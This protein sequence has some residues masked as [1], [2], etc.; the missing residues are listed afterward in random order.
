MSAWPW[1]EEDQFE[2]TPG[3]IRRHFQVRAIGRPFKCNV[4]M[5][6]GPDREK[7]YEQDRTQVAKAG[8]L[9]TRFWK[10]F[11]V[12]LSQPLTWKERLFSLCGIDPAHTRA[13][14]QKIKAANILKQRAKEEAAVAA[15]EAAA[16]GEAPGQAQA[17]DQA[18]AKVEPTTTTQAAGAQAGTGQSSPSP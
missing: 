5:V 12:D 4:N 16:G 10:P 6:V 18:Q 13:V 3:H 7:I 11:L 15:A 8:R 1:Q 2:H 17:Q 14:T 9:D